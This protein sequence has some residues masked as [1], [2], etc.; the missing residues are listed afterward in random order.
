MSF[1]ALC[2]GAALGLVASQAMA[3]D[4]PP[5]AKVPTPDEAEDID[6]QGMQALQ[7]RVEEYHEAMEKYT[8]CLQD[9]VEDAKADNAPD[10]VQNLLVKRNNAAVAEVEAVVEQ[11]NVLVKS[12]SGQAEGQSDE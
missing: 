11:F 9:A 12:M 5:L 7:A 3:C 6:G 4:N 10:L 8:S 1:R 2:F